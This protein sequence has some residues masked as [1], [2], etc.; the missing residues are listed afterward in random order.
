MENEIITEPRVPQKPVIPE[1][2]RTPIPERSPKPVLPD[3]EPTP[4]KKVI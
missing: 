1:H 4:G 2:K 3:R